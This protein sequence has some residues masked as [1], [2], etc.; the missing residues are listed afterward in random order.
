MLVEQ[1]MNVQHKYL[2]C[3]FFPYT[4]EGKASTWYFTL[5]QGSITSWDQ[6][7]DLFLSKYGEENTSKT[8]VMELSKL[9]KNSNE[10]IKDFN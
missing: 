8:L 4:F 10:K 1:L 2:V 7:E 3:K 6:F 9:K 5:A